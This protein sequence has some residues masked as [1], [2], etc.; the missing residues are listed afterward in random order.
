MVERLPLLVVAALVFVFAGFMVF[1]PAA[2]WRMNHALAFKNPDDVEPSNLSILGQI[3]SGLTIMI[4]V[5]VGT[6]VLLD[7]DGND[8]DGP[9]E[10]ETLDLPAARLES[11][12]GTTEVQVV[13]LPEVVYTEGDTEFQLAPHYRVASDE[14][15]AAL[16]EAGVNASAV[17]ADI[18]I[19]A[20]PGTAAVQI[21]ETDEE[22]EILTFAPCQTSVDQESACDEP[23]HADFEPDGSEW[24]GTTLRLTP[25][26]LES[27]LDRRLIIDAYSGDE[28]TVP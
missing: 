23:I 10:S 19:V 3:I 17:E 25:I 2:A 4:M 18:W 6:F 14:Q 24:Y 1:F 5:G 7:D 11:L 9:S 8:N 21:T 16:L 15:I 27:E 28:I 13:S 22:V 20:Q 26:V 12:F